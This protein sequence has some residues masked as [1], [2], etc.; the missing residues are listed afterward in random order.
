MLLNDLITKVS[1]MADAV[2]KELHEGK[3]LLCE[4]A[5]ALDVLIKKLLTI[6]GFSTETIASVFYKVEDMY[7]NEIIT[8]CIEVN[9][10]VKKFY[11]A[12]PE[13][14]KKVFYNEVYHNYQ[15]CSD[16]DTFPF[17]ENAIEA[18]MADMVD[19]DENDPNWARVID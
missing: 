17:M 9:S 2:N 7:F 10:K 15:S 3:T 5:N 6:R 11:D 18:T 13:S 4:D 19:F 12:L 14:G 16:E 8:D 1:E